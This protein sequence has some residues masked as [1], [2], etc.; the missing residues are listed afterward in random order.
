MCVVT[1]KIILWVRSNPRPPGRFPGSL[2]VQ[3][4][5]KTAGGTLFDL[6]FLTG[7]C[8]VDALLLTHVRVQVDTKF[9]QLVSGLKPP[10]KA[11]AYTQEGKQG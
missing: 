10:T 8:P 11:D 3:E 2:W 6:S 5:E 1:Q 4:T 7:G 9:I